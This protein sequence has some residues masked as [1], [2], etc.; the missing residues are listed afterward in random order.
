[1]SYIFVCLEIHKT[2]NATLRCGTTYWGFVMNRWVIG[3]VGLLIIVAGGC[4]FF[5]AYTTAQHKKEAAELDEFVR[6]WE[7]DRQAQQ[8]TTVEQATE[9]ATAESDMQSAEKQGTDTTVTKDTEPTQAQTRPST[10]TSLVENAETADMRVSPYGFGPYPEVPEDMPF[11]HHHTTWETDTLEA[12]LLSRVLIKLWTSG[13]R[14]FIGGSTHN[15]KIYPHYHDTVYVRFGEY[16]SKRLGTVR[17]AA[18]IKSGPHVRYTK[19]DLLNPP[20]HLRVLDLDSSGIDPY[21]YLDLPYKKRG[22]K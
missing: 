20:P 12:E 19:A 9:K 6:Q 4:Y 5:Y 7:K 3:A 13:E 1:M 15:G 2:T 8:K 11:K 18:R 16:E 10:G 21:Q 14:N 22:K 17:F